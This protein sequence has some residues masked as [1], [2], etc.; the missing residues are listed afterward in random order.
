MAIFFNPEGKMALGKVTNGN[1]Q[2]N[3][4]NLAYHRVPVQYFY[5]QFQHSVVKEQIKAE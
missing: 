4:N 2:N 5:Q 1:Y 3:G